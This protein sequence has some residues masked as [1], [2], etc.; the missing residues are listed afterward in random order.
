MQAARRSFKYGRF[1]F[2]LA[3]LALM[4]C[5]QV[6][7]FGVYWD[8]GLVDPQLYGAWLPEKENVSECIAFAKNANDY[9]L[10]L[11]EGEALTIRSL[12]VGKHRFMMMKKTRDSQ[13][14]QLIRYTVS[15]DSF[16]LYQLNPNEEADFKKRYP[17]SAVDI[18]N[19]TAT[20]HMLDKEMLDLIEKVA[21][22]PNYWVLMKTYRHADCTPAPEKIQPADGQ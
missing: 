3:C 21:D 17:H 19:G 1:S 14:G 22:E 12:L 18:E 11:G 7:D 4:S 16:D 5:I 20:I 2:F 13:D 10:Q 8:K 15:R 9:T 6:E